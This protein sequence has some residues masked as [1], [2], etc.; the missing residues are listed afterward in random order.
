M[1]V[2]SKNILKNLYPKKD[3]WSYKGTFGKV[4]VIGGNNKFTGAPAL[5]AM[6]ALR[7][8]ADLV[9]VAAPRRAAD[10][11]A[12]FSPNMITLPLNG[13]C[14]TKFNLKK[15]LEEA[16][17]ADSVIIGPGLGRNKQTLDFVLSFLEKV[18]IPCVIDADALHAFRKNIDLLKERYVLTPHANEFQMLFGKTPDN[19]VIKRATLTRIFAKKYKPTILL[20]GHVDVVSNGND[21]AVNKTGNP[22]MTI[23]GTGDVLAGICGGLLAIG[24]KPFKAA[25]AAAYISGAAGNKAAKKVGIGLTAV[26][27]I[28]NIYKVLK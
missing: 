25:S 14:I 11:I 18:D 20:K 8:G 4:L 15:I 16:K 7:V 21:N 27:I 12:S 17:N 28:N 5:A 2:L 3:P 10:I 19:S 9:T 24:I 1:K 6:A 22:Y 13:V 23:G 26:D